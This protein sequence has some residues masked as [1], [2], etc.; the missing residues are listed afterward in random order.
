LSLR[1]VLVLA[2]A[3]F[4]LIGARA[5]TMTGGSGRLV[6]VGYREAA[7]ESQSAPPGVWTR[8]EPASCVEPIGAGESAFRAFHEGDVLQITAPLCADMTKGG[9]RAR[10]A[11]AL[12]LT[13][14]TPTRWPK[15][16][17]QYLVFGDVLSQEQLASP[18][19]A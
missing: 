2:V 16:W 3:S 6:P 15:P 18:A 10:Q 12:M 17:P 5:D 9:N 7:V 19:A 4:A 8:T 13:G 1:V 11:V 14:V